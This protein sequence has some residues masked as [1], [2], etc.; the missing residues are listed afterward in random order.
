MS[1]I[2]EK[3]GLR[4][5]GKRHTDLPTDR[6]LRNRITAARCPVCARTGAKYLKHRQPGIWLFCTWCSDTWEL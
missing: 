1:R 2:N 3:L 4:P 6:A 5:G